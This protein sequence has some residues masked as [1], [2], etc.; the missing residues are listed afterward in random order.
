MKVK[1]CKSIEKSTADEEEKITLTDIDRKMIAALYIIWKLIK[2]SQEEV[3]TL[4]L[5]IRAEKGI[6]KLPGGYSTEDLLISS[7]FLEDKFTPTDLSSIRRTARKK[8]TKPQP[9]VDAWERVLV[10]YGKGHTFGEKREGRQ[11]TIGPRGK[12][13]FDKTFKKYEQWKIKEKKNDLDA[14]QILVS[15]RNT[16]SDSE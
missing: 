10:L 9:V 1:S 3:D 5:K 12:K 14:A 11:V 2:A 7:Q 6:K 8:G 16:A 4:A 13:Q 15:L